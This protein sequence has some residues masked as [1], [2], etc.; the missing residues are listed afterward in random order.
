MDIR[1]KKK[2]VTHFYAG[3]FSLLLIS[4]LGLI[5][6][7]NTLA[8]IPS[9]PSVVPNSQTRA[10]IT[11][12]IDESSLVEL[13]GNT[14]PEMTPANDRGPVADDF[15]MEHMLLLLKRPIE[16]E[17]ALQQLIE[18]L[19]N[20]ASSTFHRWFTAQQFGQTFGLARQDLDTIS[21]WLIGHGF[22]VNVVYPSGVMIDFSGTAGQIREAFHTE[23]HY[24]EVN[25]VKHIANISDPQIPAALAL[26]IVG[27]VS[28]H[29]FRPR[30]T[31]EMHEEYSYS[32]GAEAVTPPDLATIYNFTP[33]FN[34]GISG[35]GQTIAV[36]EDENVFDTADWSTF[37]SAFGLSGY[38][39]GSF[40]QVHPAPPI[41]SNNCVD[42]GIFGSE[43]NIDV[44]YA[45]AA[46]P[47]AA[48]MLA[49][50]ANTTTYGVLIA[51]QN[52]INGNTPPAIISISYS[53]CETYNGAAG[54]AAFNTTYQ[55]AVAE[56]VSVFVSAG[57]SGAAGCNNHGS[58]AFDGLGVSGWAST[59]YN[60][61]VGGTDFSDT[62]SGTNS[63]Y[64]SSTN[65]VDYGSALSY[66]PEIP[67]NDSCASAL[68]ASHNGFLTTYGV[69]GF[70]NSYLGWSYY[71]TTSAGSGGP[72]GCATGAPSMSGFVSGTCAGYP[73]PSWQSI[74]GNPNDGV[75]DLP[76]I[77]L[78]A[79][80]GV[81]GHLYIF[82]DSA[83]A[84]C[85][86]DLGGWSR[87][88]G[89][90]FAAPIMAGVQALV[91]QHAG[92][93]QGN[94]NFVYYRLATT[95]YGQGGNSSCNSSLGLFSDTS[96]I[97]YD[98]TQG[99]MDVPCVTSNNCY[100]PSGTFG[101]LSTSSAA[102][103][104]A[105][106]ASIGWDFA[107]GIGTVNVYN[108]VS[109]WSQAANSACA[110]TL[111]SALVLHIPIVSYNNQY[112]QADFQYDLNTQSFN[113]LDAGLVSDLGPFSSCTPATVIGA[114]LY[115]PVAMYNGVYYRAV[116]TNT[117]GYNFVVTGI[118]GI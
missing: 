79:G 81:W 108:L 106:G 4:F 7:G 31:Y 80:N 117:A 62:Y 61:A 54:N 21:Q 9:D 33:L 71:M 55:Q 70:C 87:A 15:P 27:A 82:C 38:T 39:S 48:I 26:A 11:Q 90:S 112:Y 6:C 47:S 13:N 19:H 28:L 78:F 56:G 109:N 12:S 32:S 30:A 1:E 35:Q 75:R 24:L 95:E 66:I 103:Q 89:T 50:C 25:G 83:E 65:S 111:S 51:A 88:G 36:I 72:S 20:P 44:E 45:S 14:R 40:T 93:P 10:L 23:I 64:W 94:P 110:A 5:F 69:S 92:S 60:V 116:L 46:A 114:T 105:Y 41:G 18:E 8:G 96:C 16:Q 77:S 118:Y 97:F 34:E 104:I 99:D 107:T 76:D 42:P 102:Y 17:R 91:N 59:L 57:D 86:D 53:E 98:V 68:L 101:I 84:A 37:R 43:A 3:S 29:D 85:T 58:I 63:A 49:S 74:V 22:A 52:L 113:L 100:T 67:W 2:K 115:L 73:K